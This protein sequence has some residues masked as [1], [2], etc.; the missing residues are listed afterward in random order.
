MKMSNFE[1]TILSLVSPYDLYWEKIRKR[2]RS[3]I[4]AESEYSLVS[5]REKTAV[6]VHAHARDSNYTL[7]AVLHLISL[8]LL[9]L[10]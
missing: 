7:H 6:K 3:I 10:Q 4:K 2:K 8:Q 5:A 1:K 9:F